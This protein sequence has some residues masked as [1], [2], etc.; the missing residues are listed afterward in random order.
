[1]LALPVV[2]ARAAAT[3]PRR[4]APY[5]GQASGR[6]AGAAKN[7]GRAAGAHALERLRTHASR[8]RSFVLNAGRKPRETAGHARVEVLPRFSLLAL[9][10]FAAVFLFVIPDVPPD[11]IDK[12]WHTV[13]DPVAR[14]ASSAGHDI[15]ASWDAVRQTSP[16]RQDLTALAVIVAL[17]APR[18]IRWRRLRR[19]VTVLALT[20]LFI[21]A[22]P[23]P[24]PHDTRRVWQ[25]EQH[26]L[27]YYRAP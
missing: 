7:T 26:A 10:G 9:L 20:A 17:L 15:R 11:A 8:G 3:V 6:L 18:F 2:A 21:F 12:M 25:T 16:L 14:T 4:A 19:L 1:V 5:A 24:S 22:P 27:A 23:Y 13:T